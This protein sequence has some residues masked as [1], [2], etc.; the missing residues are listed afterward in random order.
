MT[1]LELIELVKKYFGEDKEELKKAVL[2][3]EYNGKAYNQWKKFFA[4]NVGKQPFD[5][6]FRMMDE[7]VTNIVEKKYDDIRWDFLGDISWEIQI[8]LNENIKK[9]YDW[10][11]KLCI[12]C[13][14]TA[15]ILKVFISDIIPAFT[16]DMY[17][18]T[19]SKQGNYYEFKPIKPETTH[20]KALVNQIIRS[21]KEKNYYFVSRKL[22]NRRFKEI[23]SDCHTDG[24]ATIFDVLFSDVDNFQTDIERYCNETLKDVT[25][26]EIR[27]REFYDKKGELIKRL[28]YQY[29]PSGNGLC[30]ESNEKEGIKNITVWK[31]TEKR[32]H[33]EFKLKLPPNRV[34][35]EED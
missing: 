14:G 31:D 2:N 24:N 12:N 9:G 35:K 34:N 27:W 19:F 16:Y 7:T 23:Y 1:E 20:E 11:K 3:F 4:S 30:I 10:D 32:S 8:L 26:K 13:G 18:M 15:R 5:V 25:G 22:A 6:L 21:L 33:Q 28:E 29:F 17:S